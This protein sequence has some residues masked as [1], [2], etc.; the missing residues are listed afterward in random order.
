MNYKNRTRGGWV[1]SKNA[2]YVAT[3]EEKA[4]HTCKVS[5]GSQE[6]VFFFSIFEREFGGNFQI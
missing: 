6:N 1:K 3:W 4:L 2:T 5:F